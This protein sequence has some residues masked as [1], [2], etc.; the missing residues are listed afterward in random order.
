MYSPRP[1]LHEARLTRSNAENLI[2][3]GRLTGKVHDVQHVED[4]CPKGE[5]RS[6]VL[7]LPPRPSGSLLEVRSTCKVCPSGIFVKL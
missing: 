3:V 4:R 6:P 5:A 7:I 2:G 1:R